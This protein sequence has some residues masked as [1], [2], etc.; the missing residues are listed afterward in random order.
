MKAQPDVVR[1]WLLKSPRPFL[2]RVTDGDGETHDVDIPKNPRW[3]D[4]AKDIVNLDPVKV[5]ALSED[6]RTL[7]VEK[8]GEEQAEAP[9]A[10][11]PASEVPRYASQHV[12]AA[13]SNDPETIRM[14]HFANLLAEAH[15]EGY[16]G[17]RY[18]LDALS[19]IVRSQD[20]RYRDLSKRLDDTVKT[21]QEDVYERLEDVVDLVEE[22]MKNPAPE[23]AEDSGDFKT[24]IMKA[25]F[26]GAREG[27][28]NGKAS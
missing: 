27:R 24:E 13:L 17:M 12:P 7:R 9:A 20:E 16:S 19:G 8:Y 1:R 26:T 10:A 25:F 14:T 28:A 3:S 5:V 22:R 11:P 23:G 21:Y 2:V 18:A 4:V 6:D 15:R